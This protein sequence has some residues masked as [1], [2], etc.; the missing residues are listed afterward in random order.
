VR[1]L[2]R[3]LAADLAIEVT[4]LRQQWKKHDASELK[5]RRRRQLQLD[6]HRSVRAGATHHT[7]TPMLTS[8][9]LGIIGRGKASGA[10]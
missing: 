2:L 9:H 4:W 1:N 8:V 10:D 3:Q 6:E 5:Q 7:S